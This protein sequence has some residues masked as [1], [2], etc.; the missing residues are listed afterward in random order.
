ME[1]A[2]VEA[3]FVSV[4]S[5][6]V[7]ISIA[8]EIDRL[9]REM[10]LSGEALQQT[11]ASY[12]IFEE[13]GLHAASE[14]KELP[15]VGIRFTSVSSVAMEDVENQVGVES[16][17]INDILGPVPPTACIR[18][19]SAPEMAAYRPLGPEDEGSALPSMPLPLTRGLSDPVT[20]SEKQNCVERSQ[21]LWS[22]GDGKISIIWKKLLSSLSE[23]QSFVETAYCS[24]CME[25]CPRDDFFRV[26]DCAE[27]GHEVCK[28]CMQGYLESQISMGIIYHKCPLGYDGSCRG[29]LTHKEIFQ[30]VSDESYAK[31][32]RF[33]EVKNNP[34]YSECPSC[35]HGNTAEADRLDSSVTCEE[36]SFKY[37]FHHANAHPEMTCSEFIQHLSRTHKNEEAY[38]RKFISRHTRPCP[39]CSSPTEKSGGCNHMTCS[40]CKADW[41]WLCGQE[42]DNASD[43]Y[44]S[45][46]VFG[47][48]GGQF[49]DDGCSTY[50]C[51]RYLGICRKMFY[52]VR[53]FLY[54]VLGA[55]VLA[56]LLCALAAALPFLPFVMFFYYIRGE[57]WLDP[58]V[59]AIAAAPVVFPC[60]ILPVLCIDLVLFS[61]AAILFQPYFLIRGYNCDEIYEKTFNESS[62][63]GGVIR[64]YLLT[65]LFVVMCIIM[66]G[67]DD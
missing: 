62:E 23:N 58:I 50:C 18:Q 32:S 64:P 37:C 22:L 28:P 61:I 24:F 54:A 10:N 2:D 43:H 59:L 20:P 14:G 21:S 27:E 65:S 4:A 36:C 66:F 45:T 52:L 49:A 47:C 12:R 7:S 57:D 34:A 39:N 51:L 38:G 33:L 17:S 15:E 55:F 48:P 5:G 46:S 9:D 44:S 40:S 11:P 42:F 19:S 60:V 41:C 16:K 29:T 53:L 13:K 25:N 35:T 31:Y 6:D 56:A 63:D 67:D 26:S 3:R 30:L 1:D 8:P